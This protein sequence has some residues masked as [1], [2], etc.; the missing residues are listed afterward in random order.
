MAKPKKKQKILRYNYL[1]VYTERA[2]IKKNIITRF[3]RF[4]F[5]TA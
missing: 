3:E 2:T 5:D 1:F 4:S